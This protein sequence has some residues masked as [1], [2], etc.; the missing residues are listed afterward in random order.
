MSLYS[1]QMDYKV[2]FFDVDSMCVVWHGNYVKYMEIARC[3]L[4]S[5]LNYDYNDMKKDNFAYPIA[6]MD[7]K[8]IEPIVFNQEI[9]LKTYLEEIEPAIKMKYVFFDK[10]TNKK[11]FKASTLQIAIDI[12]TLKSRYDAPERLKKII[13][14][15]NA[16]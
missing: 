14:E 2:P 13:E 9:V 5:K 3:D 15:I 8:Y 6:K 12:P 16:K 7:T 11:L 4:F 10:K 1:A